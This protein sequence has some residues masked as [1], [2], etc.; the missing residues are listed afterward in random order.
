MKISVLTG[1]ISGDNY[2][3]LLVKEIKKIDSSVSIF[4]V[5]G[6]KLK[7]EGV[8]IIEKIP[9]G[10]IGWFSIIK[11]I[12]PFFI[13]YK[14]VLKKIEE[15]KPD[16]IVFIDNPGF[17]LK[18]AKSLGKK[19]TCYYYIPPK[20]WAHNYGRVKIMKKYLKG[21][22]AIFP[23]ERKIYEEEGIP[24]FYFGHPIV[25][26]IDF[27]PDKEKF[28]KSCNLKENI[29][30]IGILPGSRKEEVLYLMPEFLKIV[31]GLNS[32]KEIQVVFS[33][34][35]EEI[36]KIEEKIMEKFHIQLPILT[37][38]VYS[39]IKYSTCI[40]SASG[41]ANLEISLFKKP[42][43]VFYKTSFLNYII[44]KFVVK[45]N[46]VSPVNILFGEKIIPEYL[47]K[48]SK[49]EVIEKII[50]LLNKG[51]LYKKEIESFDKLDKIFSERNVTEK[52]AQLLLNVK[53]NKT[54]GSE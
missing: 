47:Q 3:A 46:A 30:I 18:L 21:V 6:E 8:E 37:E 20:I 40:L 5:G 33:A 14:K 7:E 31:E 35:N 39:L 54:N 12:I 22:I 2:G 41:T 28:L 19:F 23:F 44:A 26:I 32:K 51:P 36:K 53:T 13:S 27:N 25:D 16:I 48:F 43:L 50:E 1:E 15:K 29:P 45:L 42:F 17:N 38:N 10:E 9:L 4:G 11:K 24:C 49:G 34:V 52:V